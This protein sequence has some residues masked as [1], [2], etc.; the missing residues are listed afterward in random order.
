[1]VERLLVRLGVFLILVPALAQPAT[2]QGP[3]ASAR[4]YAAALRD[5]SLTQ[6]LR[7][8]T[9]LVDTVVRQKSVPD[10]TAPIYWP[11]LATV[12]AERFADLVSTRVHTST[13]N[14]GARQPRNADSVVA[15]F[16]AG[17]RD[18]LDFLVVLLGG[19]DWT[20]VAMCQF[21]QGAHSKG[22]EFAGCTQP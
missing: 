19:S 9:L 8:R 5:D 21:R 3:V 14:S 18:A 17:S 2:G 13:G 20:D 10:G 7:G 1:M 11:V 15:V 4:G 22:P 6:Y 12:P 16:A